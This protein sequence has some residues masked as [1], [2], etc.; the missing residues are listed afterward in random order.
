MIST[1]YNLVH[2][3]SI[4]PVHNFA[5]GGGQLLA[6]FKAL[7]VFLFAFTISYLSS[8]HFAPVTRSDA[9]AGTYYANISNS[10]NI[11]LTLNSTPDG[12]YKVGKDSLTI[13]TNTTLGY[14]LYVSTIDHS[15]DSPALPSAT[16]SNGL[17]NGSSTGYYLSPSTGTINTPV[18]LATN[19]W[20]YTVSR[21]NSTDTSTTYTDNDA[22]PT[23]AAG[24]QAVWRAVPEY[25]TED[26]F[27]TNTTPAT[28]STNSVDVYYAVNASTALPSG[29]YTNTVVYTA[30]AEGNTPSTSST[31]PTISPT[32]QNGLSAGQTITINTGLYPGLSSPTT[33]E[34]SSFLGTI[35]VTIG[36]SACTSP[37]PS[38]DSTNG[39]LIITCSAPSQSSYTTY[40]VSIS[41]SKLGYSKTLTNAY[42]YI[43]P[44]PAFFTIT[45]MQQMTHDICTDA[46][47]PT[48]VANETTALT[49]ST[50]ASGSRTGIPTTTLL[51]D[52]A[53]QVSYTVKKLAD[54][55]CWMT[56][57]LAL[58]AG[59]V[60]TASDSD[61]DGT[62]VSS[63]TIPSSRTPFVNDP[64]YDIEAMNSDYTNT[65]NDPR[66]YKTGNY[67][68]W[69]TATAGNGR[70]SESNGAPTDAFGRPMTAQN[71]NTLVSICPKG[72]RLPTSGGYST[73]GTTDVTTPGSA[74]NLVNG[75]FA[76]LYQAYGGTGTEGS[77]TTMYAQMTGTSYGPN[78]SL[79]GLISTSGRR[80]GG[81]GNFWSST[82]YNYA[83]AYNLRL[84]TSRVLPQN[85]SYKYT[86]FPV[87]CLAR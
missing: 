82:V 77:D 86:G 26:L 5:A 76:A 6:T 58:P 74:T 66:G 17:I 42:E 67:Y 23:E 80:L 10:G 2:S 65:T 15:G 56:E 45:K 32:S 18:R 40:N 52:R 85:Y 33:S 8:S 61:L 13:S 47:L 29:T 59:A 28:S 37:T 7:A 64:A 81:A 55:K 14:K 83:Y 53:G 62:V 49:A 51:D 68:S 24:G 44:T 19:T 57:N 34:L 12:V 35:S 25:G 70:G 31:D 20:G 39:N 54:G 11:N 22:A 43:N 41:I 36:S 73:T 1:R 48:P 60:L 50:W 75:D 69:R 9:A 84:D 71:I 87:R 38:L 46:K 27:Y 4:K 30:L 79:S 78:L 21:A 72:W 16:P 63:Y 3:P